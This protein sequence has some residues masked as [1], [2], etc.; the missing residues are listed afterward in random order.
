M[1]CDKAIC[2]ILLDPDAQRSEPVCCLACAA[3]AAIVHLD[4][5]APWWKLTEPLRL[6]R[7]A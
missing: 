6:E 3:F 5:D 2:V 1:H 7:S 4:P